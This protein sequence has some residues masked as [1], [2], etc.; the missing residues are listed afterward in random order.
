MT[1]RSARGDTT[2]YYSS[3][4]GKLAAPRFLTQE[5]VGGRAARYSTFD[6]QRRPPLAF[7]E[8]VFVNL[9]KEPRN[10]FPAWQNR[11]MGGP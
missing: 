7:P 2:S 8:P 6:L 5:D 1:F 11:F 3:V 4:R 9:L 10:Q